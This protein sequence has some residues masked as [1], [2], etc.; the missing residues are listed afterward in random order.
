MI[1]DEQHIAPCISMITS[2]CN[3]T[4]L[5]LNRGTG[6]FVDGLFDQPVIHH[7]YLVCW[8]VTLLSNP[9]PHAY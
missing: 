1:P 7:C 3:C 4:L 8:A 5:N 6:D 9:L 2:E